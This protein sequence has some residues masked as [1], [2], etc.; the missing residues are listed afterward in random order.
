MARISLF[1]SIKKRKQKFELLLGDSS[2]LFIFFNPSNNIQSLAEDRQYRYRMSFNF[3]YSV[4]LIEI[5]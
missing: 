5:F 2:Y 4:K 1:P 3:V